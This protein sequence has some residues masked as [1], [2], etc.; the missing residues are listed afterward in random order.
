VQSLAIRRGCSFIWQRAISP[1]HKRP[2]K[3]HADKAYD[4]GPLR[5]EVRRRGITPHIARRDI[6]SS[7]RLGRQRIYLRI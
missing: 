3:L 1:Q 2:Q 6:E 5:E 4:T 7:E